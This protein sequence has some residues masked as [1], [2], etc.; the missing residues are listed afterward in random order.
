MPT[1]L[2]SGGD[3]LTNY[4]LYVYTDAGNS[5]TE[6]TKTN[7]LLV[8]N[9][10]LT[11]GI[12][13]PPDIAVSSITGP[14]VIYAGGPAGLV[15]TVS[16]QGKGPTVATNWVDSIYLSPDGTFDSN[17]DTWVADVPHNGS[18][19]AG[20]SYTVNQNLSTPYCAIGS[21]FVVV[22]A[23]SS[24]QVNEGGAIANNALA[25]SAAM[26]ILPNGA[27]R[28]AASGVSSGSSATAG[29]PLE[30]GWTV[31]NAGQATANAPWVDGI[32]LSSSPV[33]VPGEA[34]LVDLYT[35]NLSLAGGANYGH[36]GFY[37]VPACL[38]GTYYATVVA[39]LSND[40]N[41]ISCNT[42]DY[43][44]SSTPVQIT[45]VLHPKSAGCRC[46]FP[47]SFNFLGAV[48][49]PVVRDQYRHRQRVRQLGRWSVCFHLVHIGS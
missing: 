47:S 44:T 39:D 36:A 27:A 45:P 1:T 28:L 31:S 19:A 11:I 17:S 42:N 43:S 13:P 12:T 15:W 23:D 9:S 34:Y 4:Y 26:R 16:N 35:N 20:E 21:Y 3:E 14:S 25:T 38:G 24:H 30:F 37:T 29:A 22:V 8:A 32:F 49:H 7:N 10:P 40:V 46:G 18:L 41:A 48:F 5:V 6:L 33:Y 2:L